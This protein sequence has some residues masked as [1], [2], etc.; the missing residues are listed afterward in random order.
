MLV[1][2]CHATWSALTACL[3]APCTEDDLLVTSS[4]AC[5]CGA[6]GSES[7]ALTHA[8]AHSELCVS[9]LVRKGEL[10]TAHAGRGLSR[11][12]EAASVRVCSYRVRRLSKLERTQ[13]STHACRPLMSCLALAHC[14]MSTSE[15]C[16]VCHCW[17]LGT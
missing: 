16:D 10:M 11:R 15:P 2:V 6:I 8:R 7:L 3:H 9:A 12:A 17:S 14:K 13:A 5:A 4:A 1:H